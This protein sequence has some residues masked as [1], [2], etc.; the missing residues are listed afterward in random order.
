MSSTDKLVSSLRLRKIE[1]E[2]KSIGALLDKRALYDIID[3]GEKRKAIRSKERREQRQNERRDAQ[4]INKLVD[5]P[6]DVAK[7]A[8]KSLIDTQFQTEKMLWELKSNASSYSLKRR[9]EKP[10]LEDFFQV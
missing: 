10:E 4:Q 6:E 7:I 2:H 8:D 5:H 3:P 9:F 1:K